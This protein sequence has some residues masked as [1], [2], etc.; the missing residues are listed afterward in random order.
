MSAV[1]S[2]LTSDPFFS[3][4]MP[5]YNRADLVRTAV[6]SV[7]RQR[8][9]DFEFIVSDDGSTDDTAAIAAAVSPRVRVV[10]GANGG[11]GVAR[12]R[13]AAVARG[14]Y[15]AFVDTDDA[16]FPWT[17]DV[18]RR[19][20]ELHDGPAVLFG[21]AARF[22]DDAELPGIAGEAEA[23]GSTRP[24]GPLGAT[25]FDDFL[26]TDRADL[27]A[28]GCLTVVRRDLLEAA[29]G[30]DERPLFLE[31][32][33]FLLR[34][35]TAGALVQV[36]RPVTLAFRRHAGTVDRAESEDLLRRRTGDA[37]P[38]AV[39]RV[40]GRSG[41]SGGTAADHRPRGAAGVPRL[42]RARPGRVG[43]GPVRPHVRM[44]PARPQGQIPRRRA[45]DRGGGVG[46]V[47]PSA[48]PT[49]QP[50]PERRRQSTRRPSTRRDP[51]DTI[52]S[53]TA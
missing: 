33:D 8:F 2:E 25:R 3:V 45:R 30:Y 34:I 51:S 15:V 48:A 49:R 38:R 13:G 4:V 27:L 26:G 21:N 23:I 18:Y 17:L 42:R 7:L 40:S 14:R 36:D 50:P 28:S 1:T 44:A 19:L 32:L 43:D 6:E 16:W 46:D 22:S 10:V 52:G 20:I 39:G 24:D 37:G 41:A 31:D 35:G 5:A 9:D 11:C 12:N 47:K 53:R 29:G